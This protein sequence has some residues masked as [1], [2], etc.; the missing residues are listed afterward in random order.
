LGSKNRFF[1]NRMQL[2]LGVYYYRYDNMQAQVPDSVAIGDTGP[3]G[4]IMKIIRSNFN[5][6]YRTEGEKWSVGVWGTNL[7]NDA[8]YTWSVPFWR[9]QIKAPVCSV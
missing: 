9:A 2:K 1:D 4:F 6:T 7:K 5:L 3:M 8:Q